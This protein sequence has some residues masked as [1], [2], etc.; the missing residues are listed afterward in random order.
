MEH[1]RLLGHSEVHHPFAA[2]PLFT[3]IGGRTTVEAL[4]DGLYDRIEADVALRPL[5]GKELTTERDFQKSFFTEWLGGDPEFTGRAHL[6]L[7]H[8]HD[9]VPITRAL[10]GKWLGHFRNSLHDAVSDAHA[11]RAIFENATSLA[12]AFVNETGTETSPLRE[13]SHGTCLRYHPAIE[14]LDLAKRGE[15]GALRALIERAPDVLA[16][17]LQAASL[18]QLAAL[19]GRPQAVELLLNHGVDVDKPAP[20]EQLILITPLCAARSKRRREVEALLLERRAREDVFTHAFLGDIPRLR[21]DLAADPECARCVDPAVD[22]LQITP[23]HHAVAGGKPE[24]LRDLLAGLPKED[25]VPGGERALRMA[26]TKEDPTL[27]GL[28]VA[29]GVKADSIGAGRWVLHPQIAPL[30][31]GAGG[32]VDRSGAWIGLSCTGNQGRKDDPEFVSALLDH[33]A[34]VDDRRLVGQGNDGGRATALH[35]AAKAGFLKTI[36]LLLERGAE[37]NAVD[38]NGL[39]PLDWLARSAKSVNRESV[40]RLLRQEPKA[41]AR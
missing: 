13:K 16:S 26:A 12:M 38:D 34:R 18:L 37:P 7:K 21:E 24:A 6:P 11:R 33:G 14:A 29:R 8:R 40:R 1:R 19:S 3:R 15:A 23:I 31:A 41:P 20:I 25:E 28:L 4:V 22:V 2:A 5:F 32:K 36:A 10:A 39:T 30:L 27:V 17:E 35:Y 9:L